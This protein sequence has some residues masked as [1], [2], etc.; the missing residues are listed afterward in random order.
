[1]W[2]THTILGVK[3]YKHVPEFDPEEVELQQDEVEEKEDVE[4]KDVSLPAQDSHFSGLEDMLVS[5]PVPCGQPH[6]SERCKIL[7]WLFLR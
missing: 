1:M 5:G 2:Q 7:K 3:G 6:K 4:I